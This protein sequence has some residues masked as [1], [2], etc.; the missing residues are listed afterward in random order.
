MS[1][2]V[3]AYKNEKIL[4][5]QPLTNPDISNPIAPTQESYC[6]ENKDSISSNSFELDQYQSFKSH[7]DI[8]ASYLFSEI[9][10]EN[11]CDPAPQLG[12]SIPLLD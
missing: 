6:F 5:C 4:S 1:K 3:N 9:E 7:M 2:L 11:E 12:N 10:L 8:L